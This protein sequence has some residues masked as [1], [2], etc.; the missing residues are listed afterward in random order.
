MPRGWGC[1]PDLRGRAAKGPT[2]IALSPLPPRP[3]GSTGVAGSIAN[4]ERTCP[5]GILFCHLLYSFWCCPK[6]PGKFF[7][8][9]CFVSH[10]SEVARSGKRQQ[11]FVFCLPHL[12]SATTPL[13]TSSDQRNSR[14]GWEG[15]YLILFQRWRKPG[16]KRG[17][18][19]KQF[20]QTT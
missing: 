8:L 11:A 16:A 13:T 6:L 19:V 5:W 17:Q 15:H 12:S 14:M 2:V 3:I 1:E 10:F 9:F 4:Q 20:V 18:E 7:S